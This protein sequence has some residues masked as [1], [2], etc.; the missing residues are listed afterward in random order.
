MTADTFV[1]FTPK[2][3]EKFCETMLRHYYGPDN[4]QVVPDGDQGDHGLESYTY[5]GTIFQCYFPNP[6]YDIKKYKREV[7]KKI[8]NDLKKLKE[9]EAGI[10]ELIDDTVIKQ[11]VLLTPQFRSKDLIKY[12]NRKANET[13]NNNIS[14]LDNKNF[15]VKIETA[16]S[17]EPSRTFALSIQMP[18]INIPLHNISGE[19]KNIWI[20]DNTT[21]NNN[22][23][24]KTLL[25]KGKEDKS[26]KNR[27]T[28][29]Y[30]QLDKFLEQ[31]RHDYPD[32]CA[33]V[34]ENALAQLE[35]INDQFIIDGDHKTLIKY[36]ADSNKNAF[37][38]H[39]NHLAKPNLQ[40]LPFGYLSKWIA[41]CDLDFIYEELEDD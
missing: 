12:C 4:F 9:Y 1:N 28:N 35:E 5:E 26:F 30:I 6:S 39:K 24:R 36:I 8:N 22:I 31:L 29:K 41:E 38:T 19:E 21:F 33:S 17:Y 25:L 2:Q 13:V 40:L 32:V 10:K 14:Y 7:Q 16:E 20:T 15:R 34:E 11:W 18:Q 37:N 3:W 23:S 27:I